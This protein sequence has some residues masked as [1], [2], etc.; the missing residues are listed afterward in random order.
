MSNPAVIAADD[1]NQD[2]ASLPSDV[3][4]FGIHRPHHSYRRADGAVIGQ[5]RPR[6]L[7]PG[8]VHGRAGLACRAR[9]VPAVAE[10]STPAWRVP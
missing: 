4:S 10:R 1:A 8:A 6:D 9:A 7:Q 2:T 3:T 5:F